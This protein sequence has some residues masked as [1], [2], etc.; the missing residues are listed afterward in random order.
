MVP[1]RFRPT[2]VLPIVTTNESAGDLVAAR[3]ATGRPSGSFRRTAPGHAHA[4]SRRVL[5]SGPAQ[6]A[7][8]NDRAAAREGNFHAPL[9]RILDRPDGDRARRRRDPRGPGGIAFG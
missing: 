2:V 4:R 1:F 9:F 6:D 3:P 5:R 7:A 8:V